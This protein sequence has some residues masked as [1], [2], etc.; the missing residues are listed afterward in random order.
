MPRATSS[1]E[2]PIGPDVASAE[3]V[4]LHGVPQHRLALGTKC[5]QGLPDNNI[6]DGWECIGHLFIGGFAKKK[7]ASANFPHVMQD[8]ADQSCTE[9]KRV[10]L[11]R[12][13]YFIYLIER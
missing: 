12:G 3:W 1:L 13:N 4:K 8:G 2:C 10:R 7:E 9:L 11:R 6:A 5:L